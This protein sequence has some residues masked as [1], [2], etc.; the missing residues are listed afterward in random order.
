MGDT[1]YEGAEWVE[2]RLAF[3]KQHIDSFSIA[4]MEELQRVA[5]LV[6]DDMKKEIKALR[7]AIIDQQSDKTLAQALL[8]TENKSEPASKKQKTGNKMSEIDMALAAFQS[9]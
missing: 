4:N 2:Q 5:F 9:L 1:Y 6:D 3:G 8:V 7:D